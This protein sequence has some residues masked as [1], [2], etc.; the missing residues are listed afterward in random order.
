ML[1]AAIYRAAPGSVIVVESA[2]STTR[3]PAATCARSRSGNGI[4]G[5]VVDGV[6]RDLAE[7]RELG[8]PVFA[9]GVIPIPG[10]KTLVEPLGVP[11]R[12]GGVTCKPGTSWSPT[13]R[14]SWSS[15]A[16]AS[17]GAARGAQP[18]WRKRR[19]TLDEWEL[20]HRMR[21]DRILRERGLD[22]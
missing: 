4:A 15:R 10:A 13:R 5:F 21:I 9:R 7:V 1:H 8:F 2:T 17:C 19:E 18:S 12:C 14:A 3:W 16:R 20:A 22:E 11:V 6:I